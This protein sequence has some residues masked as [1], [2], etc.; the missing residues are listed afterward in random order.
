MAVLSGVIQL[1]QVLTFESGTHLTE[2]VEFYYFLN[3]TS[4]ERMDIWHNPM[5]C[6]HLQTN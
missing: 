5:M 3:G 1:K 6:G 2:Q 4:Y